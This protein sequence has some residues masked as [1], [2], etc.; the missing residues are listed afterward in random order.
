MN[1]LDTAGMEPTDSKD[2]DAAMASAAEADSEMDEMADA[3]APEGN[4]S[5]QSLNILVDS[6]NKI[7]PLFDETLPPLASYDA[8][9]KGPLPTEL[10]KAV[11]M[12]NAATTDA[13]L[14]D[15]VPDLTAMVDDRG[16]ENGAA[17][18]IL[19]AKNR[20]FKMFLSAST[21]APAKIA[22]VA[23]EAKGAPTAPTDDEMNAMFMSR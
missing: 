13:D 9:V 1:D 12:V 23:P 14:P 2:M 10:V 17:K 5:K 21:T 11:T 22:V 20:D 3:V 16:L 8:D 19:L 15:L 6:I 7:L 18:M 4:Y